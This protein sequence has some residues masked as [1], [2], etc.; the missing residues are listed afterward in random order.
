MNGLTGIKVYA[1]TF[2]ILAG[3]AAYVIAGG[4]RP[5]FTADQ[6]HTVVLFMVILLFGFLIRVE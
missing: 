4:L 3:V 5:K 2:L 6:T 1:A